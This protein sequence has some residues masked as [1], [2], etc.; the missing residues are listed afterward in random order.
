MA[1]S[2]EIV[3]C[4]ET[5]LYY[6]GKFQYFQ[7]HMNRLKK[8]VLHI[9]GHKIN[10][11]EI[12][13]KLVHTIDRL[14]FGNVILKLEYDLINNEYSITTRNF[15]Y[16]S[17]NIQVG[18]SSILK[19]THPNTWIKSTNRQ[20]YKEVENE[21]MKKGLHDMIILN[22]YG[23][24]CESTISNVFI[25]KNGIYYTPPLT[26]GCVA[27]VFRSTFIQKAMI[28][29]FE[30]IEKPLTINDLKSA[31]QVFLTN[32]VRKMYPVSLLF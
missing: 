25:L 4:I 2:E 6:H 29:K 23:R 10:T 1:N 19:P 27:G 26:E 9:S 20:L 15:Q 18:I 16:F 28:K 31:D 8:T 12:E 21:A 22:E 5:I 30:I 32:A 11:H 13:S 14:P 3:A 7:K 24:V 17:P